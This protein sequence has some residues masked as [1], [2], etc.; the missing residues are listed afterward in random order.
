MF[1]YYVRLA[2]RSLRSNPI[3]T[4]LMIAAIGLGIGV[5]MTTLSI[6]YLMSSNPIYYKSDILYAVQLDSWDPNEAWDEDEDPEQAPWELTYRDAMALRASDIPTRQLAMY[7]TSFIVQPARQDV[8]PFLARGRATDSD[9]F[10]MFDVPFLYGSG[11]DRAA[12]A[13]AEQVVVIDKAT[14]ETLFGGEN[15]VGRTLEMNERTYKIAGVLDDWSPTP[16]YYDVNNGAFDEAEEIFV[17]FTHAV[18]VELDSSG[19]TNCWKPEPLDSVAAFLNSECVWLQYWVQLDDAD[20]RERYKSFLD[21][22]V[23][24]QKKLGRFQRPLNNRLTNVDDWL[25]IREAAGDDSPVLVGLSFMFLA[26]CVLN[27]VGLL[28]AKFVGKAP[29]IGLRRALGATRR[30]IFGQHLI[31]VAVVGLAGGLLGLALAWVG[32]RGVQS[33][34]EE[35]ERYAHLDFNMLVLGLLIALGASFT[36]GLY[37]TW[38]VCQMSPAPFL[39]TQ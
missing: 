29:Q 27:T 18:A 3:L 1:L 7:K 15:S 10:T 16:L 17:P 28:L 21:N 39:K 33:M 12:D 25:E 30:T 35:G 6:F 38:R 22:Y 14:N 8:H 5:S 36:A 13:A 11:W 32:L 20:Q 19:N 9:F 34:L 24:E 2:L 37:P 31:E 4:A 26:V 23:G